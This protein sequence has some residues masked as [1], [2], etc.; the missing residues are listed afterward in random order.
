MRFLATLLSFTTLATVAN[1]ASANDDPAFALAPTGR[2][3]VALLVTNA[4][5][6]TKDS[7]PTE[8]HGIGPDLARTLADRL[9]VSFQPLR[10]QTAPQLLRAAT[11]DVWDVTF[12]TI[13]PERAKV[14]DFT[15]P[16][17]MLENCLLVPQGSQVT[18]LSNADDRG[19]RIA[20]YEG[21][22]NSL[23][24]ARTLKQARMVPVSSPEN[25]LDLLRSGRADAFA[26]NRPL[27][28][29][30]AALLPGARIYY[31]PVSAG[32]YAMAVPKGNVEGLRYLAGFLDRAKRSGQIEYL[33]ARAKLAGA[34][35]L[36]AQ[37]NRP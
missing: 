25:L 37:T 6:V 17:L 14:V 20:V 24:L 4:A 1:V 13:D 21:S 3:R 19:V 9:K 33:I 27:G 11:A 30:V 15:S 28:Q 18:S 23:A 12:L 7:G 31:N 5:L 2:L 35:A 34:A 26:D 8:I 22:S 10:Y 32:Y 29:Q 16:Y 36:P